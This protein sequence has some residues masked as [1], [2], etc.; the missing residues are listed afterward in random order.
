ME[1][2]RDMTSGNAAKHIVRFALPLVLANLGQ[3]LYM[4]VDT[5]I[6]GRGVGV[7]AL[8]AVGATDWTYWLILWIIQAL[9]QGF[10]TCVAQY[11]GEK[12]SNGL[13]KAVT[14]SC[15]LCL[16]TGIILT[17][18]GLVMASPLLKLLKTPDNIYGDA[19]AYLCVLVS[20]TLIVMAFNMASSILRALGNGKAPLIAI[21]IAGVSNVVLDIAF[22][23]LFKWGVMGAAFATVTA[24]FIAFMYC[25]FTLK[26]IRIISV[27]KE[28]WK[29]DNY[30]IKKLLKMG[31][32]LAIQYSLISIGGMILQSTI[33]KQGFIFVAGFTATNKVYGLLESSAI[34]LGFAMTTYTAQNYG[35]GLIKRIFSGVKSAVMIAVVMSACVSTVMIVWGRNVL[36]MFISAGEEGAAEALDIAYH[37][38][39]IMSVMLV[40]LYLLHVFRCILQG[41]GDS[42]APLLSGIIEFC[43]RVFIA[44]I[45]TSVCG[46]SV[47]FFAEPVAWIGSE[48]VLMISCFVQFR[49]LK[50]I[51]IS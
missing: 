28:D 41:L 48:L 29:K 23:I 30:I 14:M 6:V 9:T 46:S 49:K 21:A 27:T 51:K 34:A 37:L 43:V 24:Q 47:I 7:E 20:G 33:N 11:F 18:A 32:P 39:F 25:A 12:N 1:K 50:Q 45:L 17:I 22:V 16:I 40:F 4:I 44:T 15:V 38:L 8:A 2:V 36:G 35:A 10:A 3:Q 26:G 13:K 42:I 19:K 31:V 5:I